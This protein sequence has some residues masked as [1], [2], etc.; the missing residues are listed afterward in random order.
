[1]PTNVPRLVDVGGTMQGDKA[2]AL[3]LQTKPVHDIA[4]LSDGQEAYER[5]DHHV[6]DTMYFLCCDAF[7]KKIFITIGRRSEQEIAYLIGEKT[8]DFFRH[9]AVERPQTGL[10]VANRNEQLAAYESRSDSRVYIAIHEHQIRLA[11]Q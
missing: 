6:T 9:A 5:V 2:V 11:L 8:V 7:T 1:M 3:A 4:L 10:D